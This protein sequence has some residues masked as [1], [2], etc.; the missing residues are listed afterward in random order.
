MH[1]APRTTSARRT[2]GR[3]R[4]RSPLL[5]DPPP[6]PEQFRRTNERWRDALVDGP[7]RLFSPEATGAPYN[8]V[9]SLDA[10]RIGN[11]QSASRR[12]VHNY[13]PPNRELW[14]NDTYDPRTGLYRC[15]NCDKRFLPHQLQTWYN[16]GY[17]PTD[18]TLMMPRTDSVIERT[19]ILDGRDVEG[20][21]SRV[22]LP[23]S[24]N[25]LL[26]QQ[27]PRMQVA[28]LGWEDRP[29]AVGEKRRTV[30][31]PANP[32]ATIPIFVCS[33]KCYLEQL[34]YNHVRN[35]K[36]KEVQDHEHRGELM[37]Y[38]NWSL[39]E[40][41]WDNANFRLPLLTPEEVDGYIDHRTTF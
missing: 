19:F 27:K 14:W 40:Y 38:A 18:L 35:R 34:K 11:P 24:T 15:P 25:T 1:R 36:W 37:E 21:D 29:P 31:W 16:P 23:P 39:K 7:R 28:Q 30:A 12:L 9:R 4:H 41:R 8:S 20:V 26:D 10:M 5:P 32:G 2:R 6:T 17:S 33:Q 13:T 3:K 22:V